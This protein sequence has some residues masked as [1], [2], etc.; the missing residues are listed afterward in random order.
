LTAY[1]QAARRDLDDQRLAVARSLAG[2]T[3][4]M[5]QVGSGGDVADALIV[6]SLAE[7]DAIPAARPPA[8]PKRRGG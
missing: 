1:P 5:V 3:R 7:P 8:T 2:N 4:A 6:Q